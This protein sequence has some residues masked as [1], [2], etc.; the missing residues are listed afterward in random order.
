MK[1]AI[2]T[3]THYGARK[4]SKLFHD[5]FL[6]FYNDIFF[7]T[8]DKEGID[9]ILHLGDAFDNRTAV[10]FAALSWSKDNIFDP[11]K[12]RGI[13]VH[14]IVGNHDSYY[15]NTNDVNAVDL[16]LREYDN[17]SV[18]SEVTEVLIDK[19]KILFIPWINSENEE[20]SFKLIQST[21][22]KVS[23]GH[24]ELA[25]FAANKQVFMEHGYDR[26]LFQKF[27]KVFSGHYHTRSTDG[28]ITYLGNPYE[29]YWNDVEDPR[30]F[31][32]FDTD[33]LKLTPINNPYR[34]FYKL[35]YNDEPASLLDARPYR[36]KIV[37]LIVRNKPRPKEFEKVVD[38][39]YSAGV[40]DLKVIENF[41]I[42]EAEDFEAYETEDTLSIL[43]R[44][45]EDSEVDLDKNKI[46][47]IME[48]VYKEACEMI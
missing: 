25:G 29:I 48:Q 39:L 16:L 7:P 27:E 46:K 18:Y 4:N 15:K 43:N 37:K 14:L 32:I 35:Y 2:I 9:T 3:D 23:M 21:D 24:L 31:H 28:K 38:K 11:I 47:I 5:Y 30:G 12:D 17:V 45:I 34:L 41:V 13:N 8:I 42:Q 20:N 26:K 22:C 10:N 40:A 19:L 33:T 6:R 1:V 36:D 44:Y